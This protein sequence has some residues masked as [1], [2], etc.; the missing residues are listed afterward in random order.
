MSV[1]L[2]DATAFVDF[3]KVVVRYVVRGEKIKFIKWL[4]EAYPELSGLKEAKDVADEI[5]AVLDIRALLDGEAAHREALTIKEDI[6][7]CRDRDIQG[8]LADL[9]VSDAKIDTLREVIRD[10]SQK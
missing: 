8:L 6:I 7:R 5:W 1:N 9:R 3:F 4:R 10:L 2:V